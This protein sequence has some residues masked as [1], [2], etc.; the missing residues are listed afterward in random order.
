MIQ[1]KIKDGSRCQCI[2]RFPFG[3]KLPTDQR[4]CAQ[5]FR[6]AFRNVRSK[7]NVHIAVD[8]LHLSN[9]TYQMLQCQGC[10]KWFHPHGHSNHL[11]QTRD[12]ACREV[13]DQSLR[14]L[15]LYDSEEMDDDG[16]DDEEEEEDCYTM[17]MNTGRHLFPTKQKWRWTYWM[18]LDSDSETE[19][20]SKRN[21]MS[22]EP[23]RLGGQPRKNSGRRQWWCRFHPLK[24]E[25]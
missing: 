7:F 25:L 4:Y 19:T 2:S 10:R 12:R 24:L 6:S 16:G 1:G 3:M 18:N 23:G 17:V 8:S 14:D 15:D 13:F 21:L 22:T 20:I 9:S 11:K 5:V